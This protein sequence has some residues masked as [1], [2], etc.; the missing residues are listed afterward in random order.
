M[1]GLRGCLKKKEGE[2]QFCFGCFKVKRKE[3]SGSER[4]LREG[5]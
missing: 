4:G 2:E 1:G 3:K 5:V